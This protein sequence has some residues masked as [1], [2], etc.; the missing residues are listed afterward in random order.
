M[1]S[2][3]R[4][5]LRS[6]AAA[7]VGEAFHYSNITPGIVVTGCPLSGLLLYSAPQAASRR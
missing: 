3:P 4:I 6:F 1:K 7:Q 5:G 2:V